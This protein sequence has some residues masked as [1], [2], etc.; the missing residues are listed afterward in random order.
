[1]HSSHLHYFPVSRGLLAIWLGALAVLFIFAQLGLLNL[2]NIDSVGAPV[3][4]S[5]GA[6]TF[7]GIFVTG[8]VAMPLAGLRRF[9]PVKSPQAESGR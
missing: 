6:G 1:M 5:G 7:D 9:S 8:I 4:S 2:G 3:A